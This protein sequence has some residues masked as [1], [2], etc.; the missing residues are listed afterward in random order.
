MPKFTWDRRKAARNL[1]EHS[2]SFE[3]AIRV[4]RDPH[5][6]D[7]I[8]DREDYGEERSNILGMIENRFVVVTYTLR[9]GYVRIISA[10][11][12]IREE[13]RRYHEKKR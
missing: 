8:D 9:G 1:R 7:E 12:A 4:F 10:R 2:I 13:R 3:T 5:A 6:I 11:K